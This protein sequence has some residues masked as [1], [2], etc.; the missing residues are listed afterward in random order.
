ML[1]CKFCEIFHSIF[2]TEQLRVT[3]AE[4]NPFVP[5]SHK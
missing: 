3:A 5:E 2:V 1:S 4:L